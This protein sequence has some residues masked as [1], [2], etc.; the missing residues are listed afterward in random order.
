MQLSTEKPMSPTPSASKH[1]KLVLILVALTV[2]SGT[3]L[4]RYYFDSTPV[5]ISYKN[6]IVFLVLIL[7]LGIVPHSSIGK[8]PE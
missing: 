2:Y 6:S 7:V 8:V 4:G 5:L 3:A 1:R